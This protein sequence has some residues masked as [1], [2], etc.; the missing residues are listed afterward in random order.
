MDPFQTDYAKL[1][2]CIKMRYKMIQPKKTSVLFSIDWW[3]ESTQ[4][5]KWV[6]HMVMFTQSS[7]REIQQKVCDGKQYDRPIFLHGKE[8]ENSKSKYVQLRG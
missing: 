4:G 2:Y 3:P 8:I 5:N 1:T 6:T 7:I